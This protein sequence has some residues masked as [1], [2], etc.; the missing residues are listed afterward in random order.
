MALKV[1]VQMDHVSSISIK[2][3][4]TFALCL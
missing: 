2:G 4:S 1:A 3:D